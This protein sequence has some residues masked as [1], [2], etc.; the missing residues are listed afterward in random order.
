MSAEYPPNP[1]SEREQTDESLR[2][3]REK[4]DNALAADLA[5]IDD[6]A[7]AVISRARAR[8]DA[9][10][11][12]S[13]ASTDR[14]P[15]LPADARASRGVIQR[16]RV[17]ADAALRDERA[18]AD[19]TLRQERAAQVS[20]LSVEREET[21]KDLLS[22]RARFDDVLATRDEFL[23]IVSHD[24]RTMLNTISGFASLIANGVKLEGHVEQVLTDTRRIHRTCVRMDRLVGDLVDVA[25]IEAGRL[26]VACEVGDPAH[27]V[28]EAVDT[29]QAQAT[30]AGITLLAEIVPPS[31]LAAHDAAR[32]LQVIANL[33]SNAIKFTPRRGESWSAWSALT[34]ISASP[35]A[36]RDGESRPP[37]W[38]R[39]S[40]ASSR[41]RRTI[42][43]AWALVSISPSA[44]CRDMAAEY[45]RRAGA[46][47]A[48][49]SISPCPSTVHWLHRATQNRPRACNSSGRVQ[50]P[51]DQATT[52]SGAVVVERTP[53]PAISTP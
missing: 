6:T 5:A 14:Q 34:R 43:E 17:L 3:E 25:S 44:S 42:G 45:G 49:R 13:R 52:K 28:T 32:I 37:I 19:E 10:L 2:V 23:G 11:A 16:E 18:M 47:R 33:L 53:A 27:L 35:S 46:A 41:W 51:P 4:A 12:A 15:A 30:A 8:A 26:A 38:I 39:C 20:L 21:D 29:F 31:A 48:P 9:V 7:D 1:L 24:L 36:I 22:E 40:S 50:K